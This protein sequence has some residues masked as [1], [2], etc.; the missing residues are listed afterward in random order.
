MP[1]ASYL[2]F[3]VCASLF[4]LPF[5]RLISL[6]SDEGIFLNGAARIVHGQVFACDF[7][8]MM[9]PGT[10]YWLAAFF[11]VFGVTFLAARLCLFVSLSGM[12]LT[13]YF[14]SRRICQQYQI[15]PCL[16]LA[17]V[18][19]YLGTFLVAISHHIDGTFAALLSVASLLL[20][21]T[22]R[23]NTLLIA[24]GSLAGITT[25]IHQQKGVLL[26]CALLVWLWLQRRNLPSALS[27]LGLMTGGYFCIVGVM[28]TYFW[29]RGALG[30]LAY[31][32]FIYPSR[33]YTGV[34]VVPYA[35]GIKEFWI[36]WVKA[37]GGSIWSFPV[38]AILMAPFAF[39]AALPVLLLVLGIRCR[40]QSITPEVLLFWL[41]GWALWL[42]EFHRRDMYHLVFG[43]PLLIVLCFHLLA[44]S[45]RKLVHFSVRFLAI[46]AVCLSGVNFLIVAAGA[47]SA[48][49]RV[50]TVAMLQS[51]RVLKFL[52]E[53]SLPGEDI[54]VY[55]YATAYYF[56]TAT[57]NP[58]RYSILLYNYNSRE[59]FQ[60]VVRILD[61]QRVRYVIW[62]TTF[63][64]KASSTI[65]PGSQPKSIDDY[66]LE[67]YLESHYKVVE[68]D[69]G[70]RIMER[71]ETE[72][73]RPS[74]R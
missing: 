72:A 13:M 60:D 36:L 51:D 52:N 49:T 55:P 1:S 30:C 34:N 40:W 10:Y 8:E 54:L 58:T 56:L 9:G 6:T 65:L 4:L 71:K 3:W 7:F 17:G 61:Q 48:D 45:R 28:L 62:D 35:Q 69:H 67:P 21:N 15:L 41:A 25:C 59:Q 42:S 37:M 73:M 39:V 29:S 68:D 23:K 31:A 66:I 63:I 53:H 12:L 22:Q 32:N 33:H 2:V 27:S 18:G 43:S 44:E 5:L 50:G 19:T 26:F 20:W 74:K 57:T 70:V 64:S 11:N 24:A 38:A 46:S 16:I 47:R 14:L